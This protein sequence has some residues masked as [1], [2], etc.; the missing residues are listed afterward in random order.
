MI[1]AT[2]KT[3]ILTILQKREWSG[4]APY[5]VSLQPGIARGIV[6]NFQ[7]GKNAIL[8]GYWSPTISETELEFQLC[9]TCSLSPWPR[10]I[11]KQPP[12]QE[13]D[14]SPKPH[15]SDLLCNHEKERRFSGPTA[16]SHRLGPVNL[17]ENGL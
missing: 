14:S 1:L 13:E 8:I 15:H 2:G 7:G 10:S 4:H 9:E 5:Q 6:L 16:S 11:S 17:S 12:L 3:W